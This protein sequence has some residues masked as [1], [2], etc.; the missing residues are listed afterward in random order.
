MPLPD[1]VIVVPGITANYLQDEY[2]LPPELIWTVLNLD[3]ERAALHPDDLRY[4]AIEPALIRPGQ[5]YEIAYKEMINELRHNLT[6][7][8]DLPVPVF[9]FAYD[10][11]QP[12]EITEAQLNSFVQEVIARTSILRHY[13]RD[14]YRNRAT[15][16]LIG[17]SMGG[18]IIAGF[19]EKYG[20]QSR[21]R[22]VAT[23][24][25]PYRGSFE[26]VIKIT[27]GTADLGTAP[28]SSR[29]REAAR[30]TPA[31]YYL[32]PDL[33]DGLDV[34]PGLP[35]SL[36]DPGL[37]QPSILQT[38]MEYIR[39]HGTDPN[40]PTAQ[41]KAIFQT[42]LRNGKSHR[43]RV[44]ALKLGQA[45]LQ[46]NDWL[47]VAGVNSVTRVRLQV[48][49]N[50]DGSP[51]FRFHSDDRQNQWLANDPG[52]R[53]FTGDG[54]VPFDGAVPPFLK[55]ENLVCVTPE[56]YGYWEIGDKLTTA[57]AGFHGLMPNMDMLHRLIVRH[58][59]GA[60]D[61][62][63]STWGRRA[64]GVANWNPPLYLKEKL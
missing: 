3:Y 29:E 39:L 15:V 2:P 55:P 36:Y 8:S 45:G 50:P 64:P 34:A 60:P 41:A 53:I 10:W 25:A 44:D 42:M 14:G 20:A 63:D 7:S 57:V 6:P 4:D 13:V 37:W 52:V 35:P 54:T 33:P 43:D 30:L 19:L 5:L 40:D 21:V 49:K 32:V 18:L 16:N 26:A 58:F 23:L 28:P 46:W 48:I 56:D 22:K 11:R 51:D 9:P 12:L 47:C 27:T 62:H 61:E 17:H 38:I 59:T 31:L 1:P 24:A